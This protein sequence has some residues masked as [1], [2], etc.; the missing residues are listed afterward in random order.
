M[1]VC[2]HMHVCYVCMY[3]CIRCT[4]VNDNLCLFDFENRLPVPEHQNYQQTHIYIY[5]CVFA[6][7]EAAPVLLSA[8][9]YSWKLNSIGN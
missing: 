7:A 2:M 3:V 9:K 6:M 4:Y 5:M 1:Y 8:V